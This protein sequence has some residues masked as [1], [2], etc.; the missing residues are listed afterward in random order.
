MGKERDFRLQIEIGEGR[1]IES[2]ILTFDAGIFKDVRVVHEGALTW[3]VAKDV[4]NVLGISNSRDAVSRLDDDEHRMVVT[5]TNGGKQK[6]NA[7]SASGVYRLLFNSHKEYA[8]KYQRWIT[9]EI[10]PS[11]QKDGCYDVAAKKLGKRIDDLREVLEASGIV[12]PFVN[13]R[14]TFD[15]LKARYLAAVPNSHARDFYEDLGDWY[16][17][18]VPYARM[19]N[20]TV[21]DWLIQHIPM[22]IMVDF[23]VG[24]ESHTIVRSLT[25]HWVSLNGAFGNNVEWQRTKKEFGNACAYC[26]K[27]H[28]TLSPEHLIPQ[29]KLSEKNPERVDLVEN[30]VPACASCNTSKGTKDFKEWYVAQLFY[31]KAR[32]GKIK[33]HYKKYHIE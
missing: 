3:Y 18:R 7:V 25:G 26:G 8:R 17:V 28:T 23:I 27:E 11:L 19:L 10:L 33:N 6:M 13:P 20:I 29:S 31:S 14:Y 32:Y 22:Q 12:K 21:K 4:C 1:N 16:G 2:G 9:H 24:I 5:D 15:N 30:I